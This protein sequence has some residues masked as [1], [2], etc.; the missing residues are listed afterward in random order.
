MTV[1]I[2]DVE[3]GVKKE[4]HTRRRMA[5]ENEKEERMRDDERMDDG[6]L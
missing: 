5:S 1:L 6:S 4:K 2:Y 3:Y